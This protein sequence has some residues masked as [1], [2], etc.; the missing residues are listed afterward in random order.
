[1]QLIVE[2]KFISTCYPILLEMITP[3]SDKDYIPGK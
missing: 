3:A 2:K 1:M